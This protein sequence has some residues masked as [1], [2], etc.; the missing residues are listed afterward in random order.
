MPLLG[1]LCSLPPT[2]LAHSELLCNDPSGAQ[3]VFSRAVN[4][5]FFFKRLQVP[6]AWA[7]SQEEKPTSQTPG[8]KDTTIHL[9]KWRPLG[10]LEHCFHLSSSRQFALASVFPPGLGRYPRCSAEG[11]EPALERAD[12]SLATG[13]PG[14]WLSLSTLTPFLL[15]L[16][17]LGPDTEHKGAP[18]SH[19]KG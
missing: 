7:L 16:A 2:D 3:A 14:E 6:L 11:L 12:F 15:L 10:D 9:P 4:V 18:E 5:C 1:T 13:S 19:P 8:R 17:L